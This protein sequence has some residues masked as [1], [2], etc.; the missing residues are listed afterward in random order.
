MSKYGVSSGPYFHV[1][2]LDSEICSM[3]LLIQSEYRK[4]RT[5]KISVF[6]HFSHSVTLQHLQPDA[7]PKVHYIQLRYLKS[8]SWFLECIAYYVRTSLFYQ[9]ELDVIQLFYF[10]SVTVRSLKVEISGIKKWL[11]SKTLEVK[12]NLEKDQE[13]SYKERCFWQH[14]FL[15]NEKYLKTLETSFL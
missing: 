2:G 12:C 4:I 10:G 1:L 7:P 14:Y 15:M 13:K 5:R 11:T 9:T 8:F 6:G 3:N